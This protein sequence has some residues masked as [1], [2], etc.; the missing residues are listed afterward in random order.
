[1][2]KSRWR[3]E[4]PRF[5]M[6]PSYL[7]QYFR[8]MRTRL[9]TPAAITAAAH[10]LARILYHLVTTRQQYQEATFSDINQSNQKRQLKRL[11]KQAAAYGY[12][13]APVEGV[14]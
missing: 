10:K 9:G 13:L 3:R 5:L 8:R 2:R 11:A 4:N 14:P 7:G 6:L 1:M 12:Q